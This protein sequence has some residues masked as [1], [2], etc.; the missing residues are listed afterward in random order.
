MRGFPLLLARLSAM[1]RLTAGLG[2][3]V[4][5]GASKISDVDYRGHFGG[6]SCEEEE[7]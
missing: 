2:V 3:G 5:P 4:A 7:E 1:R 6:G